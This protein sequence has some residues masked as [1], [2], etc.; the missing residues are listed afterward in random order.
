MDT[1]IG[2]I[3][4]EVEAAAEDEEDTPLKKK[5]NE[6]GE[7]LSKAI[8]VICLIVWIINIGNFND[9]LHGSWI[10]GCIYY[11]KIAVA[12]AVAAIPEGLP[13]VITTCL[14][15]GTTQMAKNNAIVRTLPSVETLGCTT[16]ICSDKTGTLT[17]NKMTAVT[18][19][20]F[21]NNPTEIIDKKIEQGKVENL[22]KEHKNHLRQFGAVCVLNNNSSSVTDEN[23]YRRIGAPTEIALKVLGEQISQNFDA[24]S[25]PEAFEKSLTHTKEGVL[26]FSSERKMMST[27]ISGCPDF[28][29]SKYTILIKGA[30][31]K[32]LESCTHVRLANGQTVEL[33]EDDKNKIRKRLED[34]A[35]KALRVIGIAANFTGGFFKDV[36]DASEK[37]K[38]LSNFDNYPKYESGATF[39][40]FVGIMDP[41]RPEVTPA[42]VRCKTAGVRVIMITGDSKITAQRIAADCGIL[43]GKPE[44]FSFTGAEF[45]KMTKEQKLKALNNKHGMVFSRVEPRHKREIV[46]VLTELVRKLTFRITSAL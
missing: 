36:K 13:A 43:E 18:F 4:K 7:Q 37:K 20:Y 38:L 44:G 9:P 24:S 34:M 25:E 28:N 22:S 8:G 46:K 41:L 31:E 26:E 23:G 19:S 40:G 33:K 12:L 29:D 15:L 32:V 35:D 45:E 14:A 42:I 3:Q 6:F 2:T 11:F 39:L 10:R 21:G 16:V 30:S 5:L 17:L 27:I 1:A